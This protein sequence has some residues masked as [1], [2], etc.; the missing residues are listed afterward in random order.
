MSWILVTVVQT[1][2]AQYCRVVRSR[3]IRGRDTL[4]IL[5]VQPLHQEGR[6]E[7]E[8]KS[9]V[10]WFMPVP[11]IPMLMRQIQEDYHK[12]KANL[13]YRARPFLKIKKVMAVGSRGVLLL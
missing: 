1:N 6:K 13:V 12:F 9:W 7:C 4:T 11:V 10:W 5:S 3:S 2:S 8:T